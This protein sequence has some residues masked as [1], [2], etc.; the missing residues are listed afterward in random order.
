MHKPNRRPPPAYQE[1][2]SDMLAK[3]EFRLLSFPEKGLLYNMKLECWVNKYLPSNK[4]DIAKV[5]NLSEIEVDKL[6]TTNLLSF[7]S[8]KGESLFF[9]ELEAYR[10]NLEAQKLALSE[11]GKKGGQATQKKNKLAKATLEASLKPLSRDDMDR[12]DMRR[13]EL[14]KNDDIYGH[15]EWLK[16]YDEVKPIIARSYKEQSKGF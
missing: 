11:G 2:A 5:F 1:F 15:D 3:R 6:L 10:E 12:E 16:E 14:N 9:T 4:C 7:F 13:K 8:K